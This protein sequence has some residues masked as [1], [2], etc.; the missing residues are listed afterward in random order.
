M[1]T[2][3]ISQ[4]FLPVLIMVTV[5][6]FSKKKCVVKLNFDDFPPSFS[7]HYENDVDIPKTQLLRYTTMEKQPSSHQKVA[8]EDVKTI[9]KMS[10]EVENVI[11]LSGEKIMSVRKLSQ[12]FAPRCVLIQCL[13]IFKGGLISGSFSPWL[14]SPKKD[15]KSLRAYS[16]FVDSAQWFYHLFWVI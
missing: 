7:G 11:R 13:Q 15:A 16:F 8:S 9:E 6:H 2:R 5:Q 3:E 14:K 12:C 4:E 1:C 10:S